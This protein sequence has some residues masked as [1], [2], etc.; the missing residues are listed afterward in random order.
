MEK[1]QITAKQGILMITL[2]II[3]SSSVV[4]GI[5]EAKQDSWLGLIVGAVMALPLILIYARL[6][7]LR[8]DQNLFDIIE[9]VFG[10]YVG[11]VLI[12]L[13]SWYALH[14]CALVTRNFYE[15]VITVSMHQ[16]PP[17][18]FVLFVAVIGILVAKAGIEVTGRLSVFFFPGICITILLTVV[19][20][21]PFFDM[22]HIK[23]VLYD[24][25]APLI[26]GAFSMF[27]FPFAELIMFTMVFSTF[28]LNKSPSKIYTFGL[29]FGLLFLL[30]ISL[31]NLLILGS[32]VMNSQYY[33]SLS[34]VKVI[35][36]G[37]FFERIEIIVSVVFVICGF[38]KA[39]IC[40]IAAS[41]GVAKVFKIEN[42][43]T[44]VSPIILIVEILA[45]LFFKSSMEMFDWLK[46]YKYY[47][48]PFQIIFPV[49]IWVIAEIKCKI[50][51]SLERLRSNTA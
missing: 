34:A 43:R 19:M 1:E 21:I 30:L 38:I 29:G 48:I 37:T 39:C 27:S 10:K 3:G 26:D 23:P 18:F 9:W 49:I 6:H 51:K 50:E 24:G 17:F 8:P 36:M 28:R 44:I 33:P 12:L 35:Q 20:G 41:Q 16:T 7:K 46:I 15:Y 5:N 25:I 40:A 45:I 31:R 11:K 13:F 42:Y 22:E 4:G 32:S 2:Y 14:L 47:A